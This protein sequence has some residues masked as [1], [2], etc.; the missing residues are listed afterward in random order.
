MK[1]TEYPS[2]TELDDDNV[3]ILDGSNGTKKIAK[4]DLIYALYNDIPQMHNQ[5]FRGKNLGAAY[6]SAQKQAVYNG[7]FHD[8]WVGDYWEISGHKWRI[9][10]IDYFNSHKTGGDYSVDHHLV[11]MADAVLKKINQFCDAGSKIAYSK[12]YANGADGRDAYLNDI[13]PQTF[14]QNLFSHQEVICSSIGNHGESNSWTEVTN[15]LQNPTAAQILGVFAPYVHTTDNQIPQH[16]ATGITQFALMRIASEFI[17]SYGEGDV[18][19]NNPGY[20][21]RDP[22]GYGAS[23]TS[24]VTRVLRATNGELMT[25]IDYGNTSLGMRPYVCVSG[26][27]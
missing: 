18:S 17:V 7:T 26:S 4:S 3:F 23:S 15:T 27:L 16:Q 9:V 6:T 12:S 2:V 24:L 22:C 21:L 5:I 14:K 11:I 20:L 13:V 1:I 10:D 8:L 25:T 19:D